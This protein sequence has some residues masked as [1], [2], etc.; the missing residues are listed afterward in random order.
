MRPPLSE[1]RNLVEFHGTPI[2]VQTGG[3]AHEGLALDAGGKVLDVDIAQSG[4]DVI[5]A[6]VVGIIVII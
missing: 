3:L 5:F 1:G 6:L 2:G 4:E